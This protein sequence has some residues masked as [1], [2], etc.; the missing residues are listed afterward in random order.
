M[1]RRHHRKYESS[2]SESSCT[3][4]E[5][6][7]SHS[8]SE[9]SYVSES[10]LDEVEHKLTKKMER[11][12]CK[13]LWRL[14][15]EPCLFINGADAYASMYSTS[16]HT[17]AVGDTVPMDFGQDLT[18]VTFDPL[19]NSLVVHRSGIYYYNYYI[20]FDQPCQIAVFVNDVVLP[21]TVTGNNSGAN[22]TSGGQ[23]LFLN[24]G[25]KVDLRNWKSNSPLTTTFIASGDISIPTTNAD[26]TL[27][28]IAPLPALCGPT[29]EP[30]PAP[31]CPDCPHEPHTP[32]H[33]HPPCPPPVPHSPECHKDKKCEKK[34]KKLDKNDDGVLSYEEY[35]KYC[36]KRRKH[37][38]H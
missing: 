15:R 11:L 7:H 17:V 35:K 23:L 31:T 8:C 3:E 2:S 4:S 9:K 12:Y 36:E 20:S 33:Q 28:K 37:H 1:G 24:V 21:S 32:P 13:F 25:D 22:P 34:F 29:P 14:R 10:E 27:Y 5:S 38:H 19:N 16:V 18:N 6:E 26:F 30:F